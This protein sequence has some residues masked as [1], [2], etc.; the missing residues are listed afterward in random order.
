LIKSNNKS[1]ALETSEDKKHLAVT[2]FPVEK[3]RFFI[4]DRRFLILI[5]LVITSVLSYW[6]SQLN[7]LDQS[8]ITSIFIAL[9]TSEY[10]WLAVGIGLA[11]QIVDGALG[12]A[13]GVTSNS[14]L[15]GIGASP[16][17]ASGAV[18]VAE[19]FTTAFSGISHIRFNNVDKQLFKVIVI[20]GVLGGVSG[21]IFLTSI[22]G[23][24]IKPFVIAYLLIMGIVILRKA[25]K[26]KREKS[27]HELKH[28]KKLALS[29]GFLDAVGGGGWGPIVSSSLMGQG[30]NP[31]KTIGTVN[32]AEFFVALVTG[33]SFIL[34][35]EIDHWFLIAGLAFGGLFA[36]PF[37]A[38]LTS[39]FPVRL[40]MILV[41][42]TISG[43]SGFN[44]YKILVV[45]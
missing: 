17:A 38:Y 4:L 44:L 30:N 21:V 10:F 32:T 43:L 41:G 25:F 16:A 37:A 3:Q 12:M 29:G 20:P 40:L 2:L 19:I 13:Y 14:F 22:D 5:F 31:R 39:R 28:I 45:I 26:I 8:S 23:D 34:L 11:A 33:I 9:F 42:L 24:L 7:Q 15:L 27:F 35:G 6:F 18:H 36:A 1:D